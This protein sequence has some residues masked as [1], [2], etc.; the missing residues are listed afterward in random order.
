MRTGKQV[1]TQGIAL[2]TLQVSVMVMLHSQT[3]RGQQSV[4]A[5][6]QESGGVAPLRV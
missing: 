4:Q 2:D 3:R 1:M 6:E 5:D